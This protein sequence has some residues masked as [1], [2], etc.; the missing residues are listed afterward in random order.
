MIDDLV[1]KHFGH[2]RNHSMAIEVAVNTETE[3]RVDFDHKDAASA[4]T[5]E[6]TF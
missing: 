4:D 1:K 3:R 5:S 6:L 2:Q